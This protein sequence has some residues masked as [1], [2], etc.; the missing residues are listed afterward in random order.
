VL[1]H[2]P[3]IKLHCVSSLVSFS[4]FLRRFLRQD[5]RKF[6]VTVMMTGTGT[7]FSRVGV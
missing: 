7:P 6:T 3:E 1:R 5:S 4:K 2:G